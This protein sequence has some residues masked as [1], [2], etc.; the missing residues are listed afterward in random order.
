[1]WKCL[2]CGADTELHVRTRPICVDCDAKDAEFSPLEEPTDTTLPTASEFLPEP[3][4]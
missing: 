1:M 4:A 2:V 3:S